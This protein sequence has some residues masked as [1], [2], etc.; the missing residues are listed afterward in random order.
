MKV[1]RYT[2]NICIR[3]DADKDVYSMAGEIERAI[4]ECGGVCGCESVKRREGYDSV[5]VDAAIAWQRSNRRWIW[6]M[7]AVSGGES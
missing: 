7:V 3:D 4:M 6:Q 1:V 2:F 5:D